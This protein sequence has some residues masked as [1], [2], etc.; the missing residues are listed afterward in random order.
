LK[1]RLKANPLTARAGHGCERRDRETFAARFRSLT[2]DSPIRYVARCRLARAAGELRSTDQSLAVIASRAGDESGRCAVSR[3]FYRGTISPARCPR[4]A[5]EFADARVLSG[6]LLCVTEDLTPVQQRLCEIF[7]RR[8]RS[9][10]QPT[11]DAFLD[12]LAQH[13]DDPDVLYEVGGAYDTAGQEQT[14]LGYYE[15]AMQAGLSGDALRRCLLQYGS[16]LRNLGR[17]EQS[18]AAFED[19]RVRFPESESLRVFEALTLHAAGR[20]DRALAVML[21]LVADRMRTPEILRYE[22]AIRGN[23]AYLIELDTRASQA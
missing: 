18:S 2:G 22:A 6:R 9:N 19:A 15:R 20:P 13:P 10:M 12:V 4:W 11:I 5:L 23:A 21:V 1:L 17:F 14:A 8:D 7:D 3:P 16:T